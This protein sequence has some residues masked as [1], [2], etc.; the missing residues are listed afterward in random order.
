MEL[1]ELWK[2]VLRRWWLIAL[3]TLAALAFAAYGAASAP[4]A[5]IYTTGMRFTAATPPED[6]DTEGY[7]D[8]EYYPWLTS[9]YVINALT[10]WAR[11]GSFAAEV[12]AA[13]AEQ[14]V[15]IPA[16]AIQPNI[17]AD[18]ERSIMTLYLSW[19]DADQLAAIAE[20]AVVVLE[21]KSP[22]YFPQFGEGGV[23]VVP[24]DAPAIGRVPPPLSS[25]LDPLVRIA[26]GLAAG[27]GL[28]FLIEY[29]DPTIRERRE[30][31][32]LGMAVLAV[33]PRH[34]G[35]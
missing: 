26:V 7:E 35:K 2:V 28:A 27:I 24:L 17:S 18:N 29:L 23:E 12:S 14:D 33:V 30:V 10:D 15:A 9:E 25:R 19:P 13:L 11:T 6:G 5:S 8:G 16:A 3:P 31:E 32:G 21:E 34:R 22:V 4:P 20:A 1:R